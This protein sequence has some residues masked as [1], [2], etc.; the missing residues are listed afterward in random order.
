MEDGQQTYQYKM[1]D[2]NLIATGKAALALPYT[3]A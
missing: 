1:T 2:C 3:S